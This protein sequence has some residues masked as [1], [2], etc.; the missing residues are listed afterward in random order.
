MIAGFINDMMV[1]S[2][3]NE[4]RVLLAISTAGIRVPDNVVRYGYIVLV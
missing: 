2:F 3:P 4:L 1:L